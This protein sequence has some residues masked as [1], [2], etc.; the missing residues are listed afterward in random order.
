MVNLASGA[1]NMDD[2][3]NY[4]LKPSAA[5]EAACELGEDA[6]VVAQT[7]AIRAVV[8]AELNAGRTF[9]PRTVKALTEGNM[10]ALKW[11]STPA[12][13]GMLAGFQVTASNMLG[14]AAT[15]ARAERIGDMSTAISSLP[16]L[17]AS[18]A[19]EAASKVSLTPEPRESMPHRAFRTI[20]DA[21]TAIE[22]IIQEQNGKDL[23]KPIRD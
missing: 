19:M 4:N 11:G 8:M 6:L 7:E 14:A 21:L 15:Y 23:R 5:Q 17:T 22:K 18:A 2:F 16:N 1:W 20:P 3:Y 10:A 12:V 13:D 9:D